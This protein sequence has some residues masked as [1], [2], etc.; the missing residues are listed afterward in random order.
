MIEFTTRP[1]E[2]RHFVH[3]RIFGGIKG[4][5][6][7][8]LTGALGGFLA[9][10]GRT[11]PSPRRVVPKRFPIQRTMPVRPQPRTVVPSPG[12]GAF[13]Q[14]RVPGGASGFQ[15]SPAAPGGGCPQGFHPNKSDYMTKAGFVAEG[16]KCVRNRR[17]NLSNG[18]A[19]TRSLRRMAAWDKQERRLGKT[20]KAIARGR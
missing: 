14:R 4:A 6:T 12:F 11:R 17:R 15:V 16:S 18:R 3:K 5:L 10:G 2:V 13:I 1:G 7:G 9:P 8:G 20:L 19:N